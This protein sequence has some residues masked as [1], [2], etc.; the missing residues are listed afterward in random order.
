MKKYRN[1]K[2]G[3]RRTLIKKRSCSK[4]RK[5]RK[6]VKKISY[7]RI[8]KSHFILCAEELINH[9]WMEW[10]YNEEEIQHDQRKKRY[11]IRKSG[12]QLLS[13]RTVQLYNEE[14][15]FNPTTGRSKES[16]Q[17]RIVNYWE[18]KIRMYG[19]QKITLI[20]GVRHWIAFF[21]QSAQVMVSSS[22]LQ[23]S[24]ELFQ[25]RLYPYQL[26]V[27]FK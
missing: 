15:E 17:Q 12:F 4:I 3:K 11:E 2:K 19:S 10:T 25:N 7:K 1:R 14:K 24:R 18:I 20:L 23:V 21:I 22:V 16:S 26:R 9:E 6:L 8:K 27:T 13:L 5:R